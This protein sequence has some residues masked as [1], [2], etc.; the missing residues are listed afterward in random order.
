MAFKVGDKVK[1]I[2]APME[3][4]HRVGKV[5]E[6]NMV[7]R[8]GVI[9]KIDEDTYMTIRDENIELENKDPQP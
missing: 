8:N 7:L 5:Y 3:V 6:V 4:M 1:I 2:A 9:L